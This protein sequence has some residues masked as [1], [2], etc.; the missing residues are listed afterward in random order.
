MVE[1]AHL[2]HAETLLVA[3]KTHRLRTLLSHIPGQ[4]KKWIHLFWLSLSCHQNN[5]TVHWIQIDV[6]QMMKITLINFQ[7]PIILTF[8]GDLASCFQPQAGGAGSQGPPAKVIVKLFRKLRS[9]VCVHF[10][11]LI[12]SIQWSSPIRSNIVILPSFPRTAKKKQHA[13]PFPN[14]PLAQSLN[15]QRLHSALH[16]DNHEVTWEEQELGGVD[17]SP[18]ENHLTSPHTFHLH[19]RHHYLVIIIII[20]RPL[21]SMFDQMNGFYERLVTKAVKAQAIY[22]QRAKMQTHLSAICPIHKPVPNPSNLANSIN[23]L[24]Y[25]QHHNHHDYVQFNNHHDYHEY[26]AIA[27]KCTFPP[28]LNSTPTALFPSIRMRL[29][30]TF[31]QH[32]CK[33]SMSWTFFLSSTSDVTTNYENCTIFWPMMSISPFP[34]CEDLDVRALVSDRPRLR[35]T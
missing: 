10:H 24:L 28:C 18:T 31:K 5:S 9:L 22:V 30:R 8:Q 1:A 14:H 6:T 21:T 3:K 25:D 34:W 16:H 32:N 17:C 23:H 19:H 11:V 35:S 15:E 12:K 20:T 26:I 13:L 4:N 27:T 7:H 33:L 29:T 2:Y